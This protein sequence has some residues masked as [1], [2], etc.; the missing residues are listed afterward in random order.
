MAPLQPFQITS[1]PFFPLQHQ[2][3]RFSAAHYA[4][5]HYDRA[6]FGPLGL[7]GLVELKHNLCINICLAGLRICSEISQQMGKIWYLGAE[8]AGASSLPETS[9]GQQQLGECT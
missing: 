5:L 8:F 9:V 4:A 7:F 1:Q 2:L 6:P 3:L